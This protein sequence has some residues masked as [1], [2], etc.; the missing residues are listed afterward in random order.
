MVFLCEHERFAP[1]VCS[2][3]KLPR[4]MFSTHKQF[5]SSFVMKKVKKA[6]LDNKA[7]L[8]VLRFKKKNSCFIQFL[9]NCFTGSAVKFTPIVFAQIELQ[10]VI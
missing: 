3:E 6:C 8:K 2:N 9:F 5:L 1:V 4:L 7:S 10:L